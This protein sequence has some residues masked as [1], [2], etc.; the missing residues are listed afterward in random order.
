MT[1]DRSA[2]CVD[3][4]F[5]ALMGVGPLAGTVVAYD[6]ACGIVTFR[7]SEG[8]GVARPAAD[9]VRIE[10][11][12]VW[13]LLDGSLEF[14]KAPA[15]Y[16]PT[17]GAM[18]DRLVGR[19]MWRLADEGARPIRRLASRENMCEL[20]LEKYITWDADGDGIYRPCT[21]LSEWAIRTAFV[22]LCWMH[23]RALD[24]FATD[25][26]RGMSTWTL[27]CFDQE[28][29]GHSQWADKVRT[30]RKQLA[31]LVRA[32]R[33]PNVGSDT[34][35][36]P[37]VQRWNVGSI[38]GGHII[39]V[40]AHAMKPLWDTDD[41]DVDPL[42]L[43]LAMIDKPI[44]LTWHTRHLIW[45]FDR[46]LQDAAQVQKFVLDDGSPTRQP[47]QTSAFNPWAQDEAGSCSAHEQVLRKVATANA[48]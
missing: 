22:G 21:P 44:D 2:T 40:G 23:I 37:S 35:V 45:K 4:V 20:L 31:K 18:S 42:G 19:G 29:A 11:N 10:V 32:L 7:R 25:A 47:F 39:P 12:E 43:A 48:A 38:P 3:L 27:A 46:T 6:D 28:Y 33:R 41:R 15:D 34:V 9:D 8:W 36:A 17:P 1:I 14:A 26:Q 13:R 16:R 24:R 5:E 30:D